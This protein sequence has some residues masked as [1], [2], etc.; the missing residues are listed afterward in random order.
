MPENVSVTD[1]TAN[2]AAL[3]DSS[4]SAGDATQRDPQPAVTS[5]ATDSPAPK[6]AE[7][8]TGADPSSLK[9]A[10]DVAANSDPNKVQ[11]PPGMVPQR[12]LDNLKRALDARS[13][14]LQSHRAQ[15]EQWKGIDPNGVRSFLKQQQDAQAAK[16]PMWSAKHPENGRFGELK[17]RW[18]QANQ[19]FSRLRDGQTPEQQ[20][21]TR[22]Q[23]LADFSPEEQQIMREHGMHQRKYTER[24]SE[25]P[26]GTIAE[27]VDTRVQ[28]ALA[29]MQQTQQQNQQAEQSVGQ[30]FQDQANTPILESQ[31][32]WLIQAMSPREQGGLGM[33]WTI[34]R[35]EAENRFFR[36][37]RDVSTAKVL[38]AEE[39]SRLA[40]G[41]AAITRDPVTAPI[42]DPYELAVKSAKEKGITIGGP[43]WNDLVHSL[44]IT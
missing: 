27:I 2:D 32:E 24:F 12:D 1:D 22:A 10:T 43:G 40:K 20:Q 23:V 11:A 18:Q 6:A 5:P 4:A 25:D 35:L 34:A 39:R 16:L 30:W 36:S 19:T 14:E 31:R 28:Q 38:S 42:S 37:Q 44:G 41:H 8:L 15:L 7:S 3:G 13:R 26:E 33:P 21:A 9:T 29:Q 17:A